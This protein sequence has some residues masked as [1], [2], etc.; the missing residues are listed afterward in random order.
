[1]IA[2]TD[3]VVRSWHLPDVDECFISGPLAKGSALRFPHLQPTPST[4]SV[5]VHVSITRKASLSFSL[6]VSL[7]E[8]LSVLQDC[9]NTVGVAIIELFLSLQGSASRP[10]GLVASPR[11]ATRTDPSHSTISNIFQDPFYI[12]TSPAA[13]STPL[14][15]CCGSPRS[16]H[17]PGSCVV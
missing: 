16:I 15:S 7:L 4:T 10:K 9:S 17:I 3:M 13:S 12:S 11:G 6:I 14:T 8:T 1:M 2:K 5:L